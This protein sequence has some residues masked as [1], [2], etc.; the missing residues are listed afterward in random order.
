MSKL[1]RGTIGSGKGL[2]GTDGAAQA[3]MIRGR[4]DEAL[5]GRHV[6]ILMARF[7]PAWRPCGC[8]SPC[9]SG[10]RINPEWEA[11]IQYLTDDVA[12]LFAGSLSHRQMRRFLIER[13]FGNDKDASG[14]KITLEDVA[15][16]CGVHR[17]T[18]TTH[19]AKVTQLLRGTKGANGCRGEEERAIREADEILS[20]TG[21]IGA[22][23][24]MA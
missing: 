6:A 9:C 4:I 21:L 11:A 24:D 19:N 12:S 7:A 23:E 18:A 22:L 1:M 5:S 17:D 16:K 20:G 15:R 14:K 10:H 13:Y 3:G 2:V 8:R